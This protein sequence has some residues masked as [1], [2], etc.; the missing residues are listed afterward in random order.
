MAYDYYPIL[1]G[2]QYDLLALQAVTQV[3]ALTQH[4]F[5]IIEPVKD[6]SSLNKNI[7]LWLKL[8]PLGVI[9]NPVVGDYA[10]LTVKAHPLKTSI[11]THPNFW[12][13]QYFDATM[14]PKTLIQSPNYGL[15]CANYHYLASHLAQLRQLAPKRLLI[16]DEARFRALVNPLGVPTVTYNDPFDYQADFD[17]YLVEPETSFSSLLTLGQLYPTAVGFGDF[18]IMGSY[19]SEYG[20][21]QRRQVLH[22]MLLTAAGTLTLR[23]F[24]SFDDGS[25]GHQK[26]KFLDALA[27]LRGF[28]A[29]YP[30]TNTLTPALKTLLAHFEIDKN[31]GFGTVKKLLLAHHFELVS[32]FLQTQTAQ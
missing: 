18:S 21:P 10:L 6:I 22:L 5:P 3:P 15:I 19:Y 13:F 23:H 11:L 24:V 1:R 17:V 25:M 9:T 20:A 28:V 27:K 31:P 12:Q 30:R 26:E 29:H 32:R 14:T 4:L 8:R 2:R 16:P 7:S